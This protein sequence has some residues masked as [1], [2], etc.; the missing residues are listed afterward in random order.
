MRYFQGTASQMMR[1]MGIATA[2]G[3][4]C[5]CDLLIIDD[6]GDGAGEYVYDFPALLGGQRAL[7]PEERH[8]HFHQ[9]A[10]Q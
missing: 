8:D 6:L 1:P 10:G 7:K 4:Y 2:P 3:I 5:E 9:S